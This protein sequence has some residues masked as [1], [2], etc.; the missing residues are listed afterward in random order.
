MWPLLA[1]ATLTGAVGYLG[2]WLTGP[3]PTAP[4]PVM[5]LPRVACDEVM[6]LSERSDGSRDV[7]CGRVRE[8][9]P[10]EGAAEVAA[11]RFASDVVSATPVASGWVFVTADGTVTHSERFT[12][13]LRLLGRVP[14]PG[15]WAA[16]VGR[17][18]IGR[19]AVVDADGAVW[20]TDGATPPRKWALPRPVRSVAFASATRGAA[21]LD[22]GEL[23]LITT[24]DSRADW[25]RVDLQGEVAVHVAVDRNGVL[26]VGTSGGRREIVE[27]RALPPVRCGYPGET[28]SWSPTG[29]V[30]RRSD[31]RAADASVLA[32]EALEVAAPDTRCTGEPSRRRS[33]DESLP[34]R[35]RYRCT[36]AR[37]RGGAREVWREPAF[38][39]YS[40]PPPAQPGSSA[41][42][43]D[44]R[45]WNAP[46]PRLGITFEWRG[47]DERGAFAGRSGQPG[48]WAWAPADWSLESWCRVEATSRA[49][50]L[51]SG[52]SRVDSLLWVRS[53]GP[54]VPIE[55]TGACLGEAPRSFGVVMPDAG[56]AWLRWFE[57]DDDAVVTALLIAPDGVT[58]AR[59]SFIAARAGAVG[60]GRW[61]GA[62]GVVTWPPGELGEPSFVP[63]DGSPSRT[64]PRPSPTPPRACAGPRTDASITLWRLEDR[65]PFEAQLVAPG[66]ALEDLAGWAGRYELEVTGGEICVRSVL[67]RASSRSDATT[68]RALPG[69]RFE[70]TL[71]DEGTERVTCV[72]EADEV[73]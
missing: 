66:T 22:H 49:G 44:A 50:L 61:D 31:D 32:R 57:V 54:I 46:G 71:G 36:L 11:E 55:Q 27:G 20:T 4:A 43:V 38:H 1:L 3:C 42:R 25:T 48:T 72:G 35:Y 41:G 63:L 34:G 13:R 8:T 40:V 33:S 58:R 9:L 62:M 18:S 5:P 23:V 7:L 37:G 19:A 26:R 64:L 6:V 56:V 69:D 67:R 16:S 65:H 52:S 47:R 30:E 10:G 45:L 21:V 51:V 70:G 24:D 39:P 29:V 73:R 12:G 2:L 59:R 68:L 14:C 53:G 17:P 60:L 15:R 28:A